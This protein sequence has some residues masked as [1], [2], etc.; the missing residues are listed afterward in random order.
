MKISVARLI[1]ALVAI[2]VFSTAQTKQLSLQAQI[3]QIYPKIQSLYVDLHQTPELSLHETKTAAKIAD[4]LKQLGYEV[5]TGVGE[6][7]SW[8]CCATAMDPL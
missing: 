5:T 3:D 2:S 1:L 6:P 7:A 8:A 4:Q